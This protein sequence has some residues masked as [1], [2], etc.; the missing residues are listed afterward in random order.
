MRLRRTT[1]SA[2][3]IPS[4]YLSTY[5]RSKIYYVP[6]VKT[7]R[8]AARL[9][10]SRK[11]NQAYE[12]GVDAKCVCCNQWCSMRASCTDR[13]FE[14]DERACYSCDHCWKKYELASGDAVLLFPDGTQMRVFQCFRMND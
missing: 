6:A 4:L 10:R 12:G 11:Y 9:Y 7:P 2:S 13:F 8:A 1:P 3:P 14:I 5:H